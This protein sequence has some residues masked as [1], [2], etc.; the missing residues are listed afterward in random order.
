MPSCYNYQG[1][2]VNGEQNRLECLPSWTLHPGTG[3]GNEHV[4]SSSGEET[5]STQVNR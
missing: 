5:G 1:T 4:N 2:V 3:A